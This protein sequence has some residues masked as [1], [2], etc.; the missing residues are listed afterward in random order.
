MRKLYLLSLLSVLLN[1][2]SLLAQNTKTGADKKSALPIVYNVLAF[3]YKAQTK[4]ITG[5]WKVPPGGP[6]KIK[7]IAKG[8][9]ATDANGVQGSLG[10]IVTSEFTLN[11]GEVV[12]YSVGALS[13]SGKE[14]GAGGNTRAY[15]A[16]GTDL[17]T[18]IGGEL[19]PGILQAPALINHTINRGI[20]IRKELLGNPFG[21]EIILLYSC[22]DECGGTGPTPPGC[23]I[24]PGLIAGLA[25]GN[26]CPGNNSTT[27]SL[28]NSL[29]VATIQW[30]SSADNQNF[31]EIGGANGTS[32]TATN[33]TA[34]TYFI[35]IVNTTNG[36]CETNTAS[37]LISMTPPVVPGTISGGDVTVCPDNNLTQLA[38]VGYSAGATIKWYSTEPEELSFVAIPGATGPQ[39][40]ATNISS[41]TKYQAEV[42]D[43]CTKLRTS[44]V[45]I[46]VT[47][48]TTW[49][50]DN[51][52]DGY[53]VGLPATQCGSPG[54]GWVP[55]TTQQPDDCDDGDNTVYP[56]APELC[57]GKDNN[58][59][60]Q[61][62]EGAQTTYYKDEDNDGYSDGTTLT[63]CAR[64]TG[65]KLLSELTASGGDCND[66]D[67]TVYPGAPELCDGVDNNCNG[68]V[69]EGVKTTYYKDADNDGYSDGTTQ[70]QCSRPTGYKLPSELTATA[71]DCNDGDNT[72]YPGAP[73]LCDGKDNNCNGQVDEGV[74]T[75][76]YKDADNDG[77][78]DG[79][80]LAQC[81]R[82]TGYKLPS[83]LTA[84]AGDCN[85]GDNTVYPGAPELCDGRDNNCNGQI[86][87]GVQTTYYKDS[88]NDSYSDGIT[89][90][91]C[92][93]PVGYKLASELTA[94][95]GDCDDS[96]A[97]LNPATLWYKDA[98]NDGYS[99]GT[100]KT[101][102]TR[103]TGYKLASELNATSGD[104]NDSNP[105]IMPATVWY[106]DI[107]NDGYSDGTV[108]T[109]CSRPTGYKLA[110]E[111]KAT[112]GDCNDSKAYVNPGAPEIC[113]NN[114]DD[115]C[116]GLVDEI[117]IS[118]LTTSNITS[119]SAKLTWASS[120]VALVFEVDY[121]KSSSST[122]LPLLQLGTTRSVT[123]SS[124]SKNQTYNWRIRALCGKNWTSYS[125]VISFTTLS[126]KS[127]V[128]QSRVIPETIATTKELQARA[129][130]NPT[131]TNFNIVV[132]G[133]DQ[134]DKIKMVVVDMYGRII[135]QRILSNEGTITIG[136]RYISGVYIVRFTQGEQNQELKL[137]KIS[138]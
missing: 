73:E 64:P 138:Q 38:V 34:N 82:P 23:S 108:K 119:S 12:N 120:C 66:A 48:S 129:T 21:G 96:K 127:T 51:D 46:T 45:Q 18:A 54:T 44:P 50:L 27:M 79:T 1:S 58:C 68:Q 6:F 137:I 104:C 61:V 13:G 8:A 77:Y 4:N 97:V 63:Q 115:N 39:Y 19:M 71:G 118:N 56:G 7:I 101:Q 106:K 2:A 17:V 123:I 131:N 11:S 86:D 62:D 22:G 67:N 43:G 135:E 121:K 24:N 28:T 16:D 124:L 109:Q 95:S 113:G 70:T 83:E 91:Q 25:P 15:L 105:F 114:I 111:L 90:T 116:N 69:D 42:T 125:A 72:V 47:A 37:V 40:N 84:T 122:W 103:A 32:Y 53:Y 107:D 29:H 126:G 14:N 128:T 92:A 134:A 41:T 57:D 136:D 99:D 76:Y 49:V 3:H 55:Q 59:N 80:T 52:G 78:S 5:S 94:T 102:C 133:N 98:D 35:A 112:A 85:D 74:K 30:A 110:S 89:I 132:R 31:T 87:E 33:L 75:T 26:L 65:Y 10:E 81:A 9:K 88:D 20:S 117:T 130:P 36:A 100:T 93:R 60:N